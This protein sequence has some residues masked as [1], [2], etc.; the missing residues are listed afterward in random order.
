MNKIFGIDNICQE[1]DSGWTFKKGIRK[2]D[3]AVSMQREKNFYNEILKYWSID[4]NASYLEFLIEAN[5]TVQE[6]KKRG[7]AKESRAKQQ[8]FLQVLSIA[9]TMPKVWFKPSQEINDQHLKEKDFCKYAKTADQVYND[10]SKYQR[11]QQVV[12]YY[13]ERS[14]RYF[15]ME[16]TIPSKAGIEF[17]P[18]DLS[19]LFR[20]ECNAIDEKKQADSA[21]TNEDSAQA[22]EEGAQANEEGAQANEEGAQ[23]NEEGAQAN[24]EGAQ[25][26]EEGAQANRKK[27]IIDLKPAL[28]NIRKHCLDYERQLSTLLKK[29]TNNEASKLD[30]YQFMDSV[31]KL[32]KLCLVKPQLQPIMAAIII[33]EAQYQ[34]MGLG[35]HA[36]SFLLPTSKEF[37]ND[38]DLPLYLERKITQ[39]TF[40]ACT[41]IR[42]SLA[43]DLNFRITC[44]GDAFFKLYEQEKNTSKS[45]QH[46]VAFRKIIKNKTPFAA[47]NCDIKDIVIDIVYRVNTGS[48]Q[49]GIDDVN[50]QVL[51]KLMPRILWG[52]GKI[53]ELCNSLGLSESIL[54][55]LEE[56][57][58]LMDPENYFW[59]CSKDEMAEK[60]KTKCPTLF[61]K[62][63]SGESDQPIT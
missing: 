37:P 13:L 48:D 34:M 6:W 36:R 31:E 52:N 22:N 28:K 32:L 51:T 2:K 30:N 7:Y 5:H 17:L 58:N 47:P 4:Q 60:L 41:K 44:I 9:C 38:T 35:S 40:D 62:K 21:S 54:N 39:V 53:S 23:A 10:L 26:N 46:N 18:V 61:N 14:Q 57:R 43:E 29:V 56:Y 24:E 16:L 27:L 25:A 45:R 59:A 11:R 63:D 19:E 55:L 49:P 1:N 50:Q 3:A 8:E 12:Y 20:T 15:S 33:R 42:D